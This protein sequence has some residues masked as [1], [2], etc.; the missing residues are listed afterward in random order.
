MINEFDITSF[1]AVGD[2]KTDCTAAIQA[3]LD[4]AAPVEGCVRVPSG[5]FL[6]GELRVPAAVTLAGTHNWSFRNPGGSRL[7]LRSASERCLLNLNAAFGCTI[8]GLS[9]DGGNLGERIHGIC[10]SRDSYNGGGQEDSFR[11]EDCKICRFTGD[12]I[13]LDR[14]WCFTVRHCMS[15]MN[16]GSGLF[17]NGWDGFVLDNW[18]TANGMG[19]LYSD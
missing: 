3:A 18:L 17:V 8:K 11:I 13:R 16:H 1:G 6:C 15:G 4:A 12:G 2:G 5:A 19:G 7:V 14:I 10:V 9:L